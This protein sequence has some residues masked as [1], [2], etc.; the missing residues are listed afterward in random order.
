MGINQSNS[1]TDKCQSIINCHLAAGKIAKDG[2]GP[3]SITGQPDAIGG[4]EVGGL[5][6]QLAAHMDIENPEHRSTVQRFWQS[7]TM[8]D[9]AGYKAIDLF[10]AMDEGK[11]KAVWIMATNPMVSLPDGKKVARALNK[12][13]FVV[14]S[15]CAEN[16]DTLDFADVKL[17]ATPWLEKNGT[18]TN[19]ERRISRQ[20]NAIAP[21]N[22]HGWH[23]YS[24]LYLNSL[25]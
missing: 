13:E 23:S 5:S 12:C 9:K 18:V 8:A 11:I 14:V 22:Y 17:P 20:T 24:E 3:F 1:G 25:I 19:S 6:N 21:K 10:D 4:R 16:N 15:D 2:C 7:P